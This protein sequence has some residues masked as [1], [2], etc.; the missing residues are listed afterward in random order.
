MMDTKGVTAVGIDELPPCPTGLFLEIGP[1]DTL[2]SIA[3]EQ[4]VAVQEILALNPGIDPNNLR[5]GMVICLPL[6]RP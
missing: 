1:G 6:P 5:V 3:R 4:G 2:F